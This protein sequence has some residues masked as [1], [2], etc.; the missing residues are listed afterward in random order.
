MFENCV[1]LFD[2]LKQGCACSYTNF[3]ICGYPHCRQ[4]STAQ[5]SAPDTVETVQVARLASQ[6]PSQAE[7]ID[8]SDLKGNDT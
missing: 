3:Y 8:D 2:T 7:P 4:L 1:K 5:S 6:P